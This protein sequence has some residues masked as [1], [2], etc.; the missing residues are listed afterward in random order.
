MRY[1]GI[2]LALL[3]VGP[4][5]V[6]SETIKVTDT[7]R[8][9]SKAPDKAGERVREQV[10]VVSRLVVSPTD[11]AS[12]WTVTYVEMTADGVVVPGA[13]GR[14]YGVL[15]NEVSLSV[16]PVPPT[17][18]EGL[19]GVVEDL[20]S[21]RPLFEGA[22]ICQED[23]AKLCPAVEAWLRRLGQAAL[24]RRESSGQLVVTVK[25]PDGLS[26]DGAITVNSAVWRAD[27]SARREQEVKAEVI[28]K[29]G[30]VTT[31]TASTA[32]YLLERMFVKVP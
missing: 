18:E 8:F 7:L 30:P 2:I 20:A 1:L 22:P 24:K 21:L 6:V 15:L 27:L 3:V 31:L 11:A 25:T 10:T 23:E 14:V 5:L 17:D 12:G 13:Q 4:R 19:A 9:S 32:H 28:N 16:K 26:L 29:E